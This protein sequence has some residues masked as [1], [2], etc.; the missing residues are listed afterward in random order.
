MNIKR[1]LFLEKGKEN[2]KTN[3]GGKHM[4]LSTLDKGINTRKQVANELGWSTGK[5]ARAEVV[6]KNAMQEQ[7]EKI[8]KGDK[9]IHKVYSLLMGS[10]KKR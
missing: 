7:I 1:E 8:R 3:I 9:T 2:L 10:V 5:V 6:K 4:G